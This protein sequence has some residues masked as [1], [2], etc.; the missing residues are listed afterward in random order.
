MR[1]AYADPPYIGQAQKHYSHDPNCREVD[2]K[3]LIEMLCADFDAWALSASS[4]SLK[5]ILKLCP[6][7]V[8]VAPWVKPFCAFKKNVN[9]AYTWEPIIFFGGRKRT[10]KQDTLRDWIAES[11]TM[12]K[13]LAGAKPVKVCYFIFQFLN[14]Q[15]ED[16]FTDLYPGTG[17]V[18]EAWESWKTQNM[19]QL[20]LKNLRTHH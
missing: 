1:V 14:M 16:K 11:I 12:K 10:K 6:V 8:R 18:T 17:I 3:K 19:P 2:H 15:A 13:G 9:P 4:P 7:G 20:E 5:Q